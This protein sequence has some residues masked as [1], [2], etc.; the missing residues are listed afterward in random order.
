MNNT[1]F[2]SLCLAY[3]TYEVSQA[4]L[5]GCT[6]KSPQSLGALQEARGDVGQMEHSSLEGIHLL[7]NC[8]VVILFVTRAGCLK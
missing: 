7:F 4:H 6:H 2:V 1:V 5:E 8:V 3:F